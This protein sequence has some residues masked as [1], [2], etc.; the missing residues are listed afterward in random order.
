MTRRIC[1]SLGCGMVDIWDAID[2]ENRSKE[3]TCD[4]LMNK[5]LHPYFTRVFRNKSY[6]I[7]RVLHPAK[8]T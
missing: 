3:K 7:L 4:L 2:P 1:C 5:D 8:K 6:D